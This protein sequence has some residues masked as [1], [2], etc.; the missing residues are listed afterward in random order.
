MPQIERA[1]KENKSKH[2]WN[3]LR[4]THHIFT[5]I[6]TTKAPPPSRKLY[7][8]KWPRLDVFKTKLYV[9]KKRVDTIFA[10]KNWNCR[11][12]CFMRA[13][14]CKD[15]TIGQQRTNND[16]F[17]FHCHVLFYF[18]PAWY[19][20]WGSKWQRK[21]LPEWV[22]V[23]SFLERKWEKYFISFVSTLISCRMPQGEHW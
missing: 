11:R 19:A 4:Y 16:I 20:R 2:L 1:K 5:E 18:F 23:L 6:E 15:I 9:R 13:F 8:N 22:T 3:M 10:N 12:E 17:F 21:P 14:H 7:R